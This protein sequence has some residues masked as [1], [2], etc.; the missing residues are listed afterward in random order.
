[1]T[2]LNRAQRVALDRVYKRGPIY[3][4]ALAGSCVPPRQMTYLEFRRTVI[5][6]FY[7]CVM[8]QWQ[9]MWLGIEDDG[10]V[11]S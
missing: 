10:Y 5:V 1:M 3:H 9:G 8:V 4:A 6:T 7:D 11:H 2:K